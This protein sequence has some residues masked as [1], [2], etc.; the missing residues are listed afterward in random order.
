[1]L[2]LAPVTSNFL[3]EVTF[4]S[5]ILHSIHVCE[6]PIANHPMRVTDCSSKVST[7]VLI[8]NER[9]RSVAERHKLHFL[10][11]VHT[12]HRGILDERSH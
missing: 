7:L 11:T 5:W 9:T 3:D 8:L 1:M 4:E 6:S 2:A 10:E 12:K